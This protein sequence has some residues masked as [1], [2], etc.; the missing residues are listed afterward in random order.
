MAGNAR[1]SASIPST[2][3]NPPLCVLCVLC[4]SLVFLDFPHELARICPSLIEP[5]RPKTML[6][7]T[8]TTKKTK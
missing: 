1:N 5:R 6:K 3:F 2:I 8:K 7:T 4:G